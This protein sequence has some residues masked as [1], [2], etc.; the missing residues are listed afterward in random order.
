M[1]YKQYLKTENKD[2]FLL[3]ACIQIMALVMML[4]LHPSIIA[5][6]TILLLPLL[7]LLRLK[8]TLQRL[9]EIL[10]DSWRNI[11]TFCKTDLKTYLK[12]QSRD[13]WLFAAFI[14]FITV[15]IIILHPYTFRLTDFL[16]RITLS[17]LLSRLIIPLTILF[18]PVIFLVF[19]RS[20]LTHLAHKPTVNQ[21]IKRLFAFVTTYIFPILLFL[22][23]YA[24]NNYALQLYTGHCC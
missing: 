1:N 5:T 20:L 19:L 10:K 22:C 18:S 3:V 6:I 14:Q 15:A 21:T 7:F 2:I 13:P 9:G 11:H 23:Y 24:A 12:N 17:S 8:E 16:N 4:F